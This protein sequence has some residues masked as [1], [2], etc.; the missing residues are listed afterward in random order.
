MAFDY[1]Y[2]YDYEYGRSR[3]GRGPYRDPYYRRYGSQYEEPYQGRYY[4][5]QFNEP[6]RSRPYGDYFIEPYSG[7]YDY[8]RSGYRHRYEEPYRGSDEERY[9]EPYYRRRPHRRA[10][11][12]GFW[13]RAG[14]EVRSWFGDEEA[15][16]RRHIDEMRMGSFAGRGPRG[17]KRSD[18]RIR[19][20]LND[21]LT[22]DS[23][24]DASEIEVSVL[25]CV[26]TLTGRVDSRYD[27]RRA[28]DIAES[29]SGVTD[30][31]NQ[32]RVNLSP[33]LTET[34]TETTGTTRTRSARP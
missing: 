8:G 14:D 31:I 29:V 6:Y 7:Y 19:E 23:Y 33:P 15:E 9:S 34:G 27:K 2:D 24:L 5:S 25:D 28:L 3:S 11:D 16:R 17:Y 12:R 18:E 30:V 32:L 13:E 10:E 26:V 22:D 1:D 20:D 21:R 4:S